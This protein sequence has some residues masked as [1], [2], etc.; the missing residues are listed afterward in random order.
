MPKIETYTFDD[1]TTFKVLVPD[2]LFQ[3]ELTHGRNSPSRGKEGQAVEKVTQTVDEALTSVKKVA[4]KFKEICREIGNPD[5]V[6]MEFGIMATG[7]ADFVFVN[8]GVE[9]SFKFTITWK[10]G[11][12]AK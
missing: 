7:N 10:F 5:E 8:A 11:S 12:E 6:S 3:I 4:K 9:A 2:T 1:G